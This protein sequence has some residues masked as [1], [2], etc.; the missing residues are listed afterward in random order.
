MRYHNFV[1][2]PLVHAAKADHFLESF[3]IT[4]GLLTRCL[5]EFAILNRVCLTIYV[6]SE[7][8]KS[9]LDIFWQGQIHVSLLESRCAD[10]A[11]CLLEL[12]HMFPVIATRLHFIFDKVQLPHV[13]RILTCQNA[14]R[15][16]AS[17]NVEDSSLLS[18]WLSKVQKFFCVF[19]RQET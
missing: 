7:K 4:G 14:S 5:V 8:Y 1:T 12:T 19:L 15:R 6:C 13:G 10:G 11:L 16:T 9:T 18:N 2:Y 17:D 3:N